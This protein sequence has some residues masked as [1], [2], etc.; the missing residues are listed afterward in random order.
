MIS[1]SDCVAKNRSVRDCST[2]NQLTVTG[3]NTATY[4]NVFGTVDLVNVLDSGMLKEYI[5]FDDSTSPN[6]IQFLFTLDGMTSEET[7][8]GALF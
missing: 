2:L 6:A 1:A 4:A 5:I 7:G 8:T 3:S